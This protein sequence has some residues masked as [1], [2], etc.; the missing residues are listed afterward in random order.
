MPSY[1]YLKEKIEQILV[2]FT[3]ECVADIIAHIDFPVS[4]KTGEYVVKKPEIYKYLGE[5]YSCSTNL[6][7]GTKNY[8]IIRGFSPEYAETA[9]KDYSHIYATANVESIMKRHGVSREEAEEI[10]N[11]R[12]KKRSETFANKTE[13]ELREIN[14]KKSTGLNSIIQR[15]GEE[16]GQKRWDDRISRMSFNSSIEGYIQR[17]GEEEGRERFKEVCTKKS[18]GHTLERLYCKFW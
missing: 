6:T 18:F 10:K 12:V 8:W 15:Y 17:Y 5:K 11:K 13:E 4:K 7:R 16:E 14:A 1:D 3:D 2:N 9:I